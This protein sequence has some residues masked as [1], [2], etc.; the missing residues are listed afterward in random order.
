VRPPDDDDPS[1]PEPPRRRLTFAAWRAVWADV[2]GPARRIVFESLPEREQAEA[3]D[4]L[5]ERVR[6]WDESELLY[7]R[8]LREEWPQ[9]RQQPTQ[10]S[11]AATST[12]PGTVALSSGDDPLKAVPPTVYFEALAGIVVPANGWVSCPVPGHE[13]RHPSCQVSS[14][15]WRCW[16]CGAGGSI[17]DLAAAIYGIEPTGR[18]YHEIRR[19][20]LADLGLT[21][22][23]V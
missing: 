2:P 5:A 23:S 16:S 12:R 21:R 14:T 8:R 4:D 19:R 11:T 3:W 17:I 20:L 22:G 10:R 7:E 6:L 15:K 13:D 9:P 18:G 1:E